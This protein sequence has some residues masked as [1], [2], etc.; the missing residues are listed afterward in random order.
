MAAE[1]KCETAPVK[2]QGPGADEVREARRKHLSAGQYTFYKEPLMLVRGSGQYCWDETGRRYIDAYSN[3]CHVGHA[4]PAVADACG[5]AMRTIV[6]NTRYLHPTIGM[7]AE[8]LKSKFPS[9]LDVCYFVNSG[10]EANDLALRL[11]RVFTRRSPVVCLDHAYHGTTGSCTGISTCLSTGSQSAPA[12]FRY[13]QRDVYEAPLPDPYRGKYRGSD[14]QCGAKYVGDFEKVCD[15]CWEPPAAFIHES[16][17][18][19]GGQI[20]YPPDFLRGAYKATRARGGVCIADEVQTG[21]GRSGTHFWAFETQ[22]VVPDIVVLGKPIGN[23]FPLGAVVTTREIARAFD[24]CQY[25]NTAGGNPV[26]CAAG[27]A[28][29]KVIEEEGLQANA[30]RT[31]IDFIKGL[32]GLKKKHALVGDVRGI[33]MYI[34]VELVRDRELLTPAPEET[35]F[36][37]ER[38]RHYGFLVG[39]GGYLSN[40]VRMKGPLPFTSCDAKALCVALDRVLLEAATQGVRLLAPPPAAGASATTYVF[41]GASTS[42]EEAEA[43]T[44]SKG[45]DSSREGKAVKRGVDDAGMQQKRKLHKRR[46]LAKANA[47]FTLG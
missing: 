35:A 46:R 38:M 8:K 44:P 13:H 23:G 42:E 37:M 28:V 33:G 14:P 26:S 3:V 36:V 22:G 21:F 2:Y 41:S 19:V 20:V 6:T 32:R 1:T 30:L 27:L 31:S 34:G 4:H 45:F 24:G 29:L 15:E 43:T 18:G 16:S 40:V 7:Y 9:S 25:F 47:W 39:K 17:Q 5:E 11:A 12:D 10:S